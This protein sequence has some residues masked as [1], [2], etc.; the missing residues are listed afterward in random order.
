MQC[1]ERRR[2]MARPFLDSSVLLRHL[3]Q[4]DPDESVRA[5]AFLSRVEADEVR[6]RTAITVV[7]EVVFAL[8]HVYHQ[9]RATIREVFLPLLD[10]PGIIL[11]GKQRLGRCST[12]MSPLICPSPPRITSP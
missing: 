11:S 7:F 1:G 10:M 5:T 9:P 4:D 2:K 3:L 6:V 8:E 12:C